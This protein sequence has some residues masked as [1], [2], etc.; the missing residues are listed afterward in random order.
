MQTGEEDSL[1]RDIAL[2]KQELA[3]PSDREMSAWE[4]QQRATL[5][6]RGDNFAVHP[7]RALAISTPNSASGFEVEHERHIRISSA[8]G[9]AAY[10]VLLKLPAIAEPVTGLR[11]RFLPD[12]HN[13]GKL[14]YGKLNEG[15]PATTFVMTAL[16]MSADKAPGDQI[17][18]HHLIGAQQVTAS[19]W[20]EGYRPE[21]ILDPRYQNGWAP[22]L[23]AGEPQ[24]LTYT[25]DLAVTAIDT[26]YLTVQLNFGH[27]KQ[28][29]AGKI[30]I[31]VITGVDDGSNLPLEVIATIETPPHQRSPEQQRA[32]AEY[33]SRHAP[34][35]RPLRIALANAR[36]RL[37]V[38]TEYF[39]TMIMVEAE[40]P[41]AT[42]VLARGDY[43]QPG[44][45][46]A[47][48]TPEA[49]PVFDPEMPNNRLGLAKWLVK[50]GHPLTSRVVV[51]RV[52]KQFFGAG[53]VRTLAD[54]GSQG[55]YPT[56]PE[57]L[58]WLSVDFAENGWDV[59]RL[60][61]KIVTSSTYRQ[62]SDA[63]GD[64]QARDPLN[65]L[66]ARGPR[67]RLQAE[68]V[69]D[70]ALATSGLLKDQLGGPSVNPYA[71]G[72]L[73]R[74]VSH[75]GS[76][77]ATAQA[78][79]QDHG[80]KLYRRSLYTYW[81]RTVPPPNLAAFDAPSRETCVVDRPVTNTPLQA[82]VLLNDP[83]FVEA[84]RALAERMITHDPSD[85]TRLRWGVLESLS[86]PASEDEL[87]ILSQTLKRERVRYAGDPAAAEDLLS[88]GESP[89]DESI[90]PAEHAAWTQV[91]TLLLNLSEA[92][93]RN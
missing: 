14:G 23:T 85:D 30:E 54:F 80:E 25:F 33:F 63:S 62:A 82:L 32:L 75:Y 18:L 71:P 46:V 4:A 7:T 73:W 39:S 36:E 44:E 58:D 74:E 52:W 57:L 34:T 45:R 43:T 88:V 56:H 77:P 1:R 59:K 67:F 5:A 37:S 90:S 28:L 83:Q 70:S 61:R 69:R 22:L 9:F 72:D 26:P 31:D 41:R 2:L 15:D 16:S 79:V 66:L 3:R 68:L 92:I 48:G 93:T 51:N 11:V 47:A 89:R 42:Y 49:L 50:P 60:V 86:R 81:K 84:A 19:S 29:V 65:E 24:H 35:N 91:A 20:R 55:S 76:T 87:A 64:L 78:F 38:L 13:Q 40:Q 12:D 6:R 8:P 21:N 53:L 10:D 27:G 17:N